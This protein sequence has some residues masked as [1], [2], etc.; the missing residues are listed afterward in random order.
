MWNSSSS[1]MFGLARERRDG[2]G[3]G[4]SDPA[5][6]PP[7]TKA[8]VAVGPAAGHPTPPAARMTRPRPSLNQGVFFTKPPP[9]RDAARSCG[10]NAG[11]LGVVPAGA[12]AGRDAHIKSAKCG[13][14]L[15]KRAAPESA[16]TT[17]VTVR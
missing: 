1:T 6:E 3:A 2:V 4:V 11:A 9:K 16:A 5:R 7:A 17:H 14:A 15:A 12:R 8:A 10:R 13:R